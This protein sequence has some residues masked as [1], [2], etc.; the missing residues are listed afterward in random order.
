MTKIKV[1]QALKKVIDPE[2]GLNIVDLGLIYRI[3]IDEK[4]KIIKVLMTL[5]SISCPFNAFLIQQA[6]ETLANLNFGQVDLQLT[7]EPPWDPKMMSPELKK[8]F[9]INR[10]Q[11]NNDS[12]KR[13]R[14]H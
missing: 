8:K 6:E 9:K 12:K 14:N 3:D 7:F 2:L 10:F 1:L 4:R 5:T 13:K 11:S